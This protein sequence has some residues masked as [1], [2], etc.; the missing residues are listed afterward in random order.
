MAKSQTS[1]NFDNKVIIHVILFDFAVVTYFNNRIFMT[2]LFCI[3]AH[4][5][6]YFPNLTEIF[7]TY[8]LIQI[9]VLN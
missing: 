9:L 3:L 4:F 1:R 2:F 5:S 6:T 7:Q 8:I